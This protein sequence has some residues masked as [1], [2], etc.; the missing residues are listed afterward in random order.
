MTAISID[1]PLRVRGSSLT[2]MIRFGTW[3][4]LSSVRMVRWMRGDQRVVQRQ[5]GAQHHEQPDHLVVAFALA[6]GEPLDDLRHGFEGPVDLGGA[7]AHAA[8]VERGVAAA[9][10]DDAARAA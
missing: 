10:D 8:G 7:D 2:W 5:P 6:D 9:V 3:R 1:L 4:G